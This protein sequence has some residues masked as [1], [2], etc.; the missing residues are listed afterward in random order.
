MQQAGSGSL[1]ITTQDLT[2][3]G[4]TLLSNGSLDLQG[5]S[6]DLREGTTTAQRISI[7]GDSV[8]TAG[9]QLSALG[10]QPFSCRPAACSTI[11]AERWAAMAPSTYAQGALSTTMAS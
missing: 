5:D 10:A 11:P 9:G 1:A 2:G 6:L 3:A 8:I 4:G 7:D